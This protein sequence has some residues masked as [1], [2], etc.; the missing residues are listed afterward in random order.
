MA[1]TLTG[2][3][4]AN[5]A[6]SQCADGK[7]W[8]LCL[9]GNVPTS[10]TEWDTLY[11]NW[12]NS[13]R[14]GSAT[15][16]YVDPIAGSNSNAGTSEAP[17]ADPTAAYAVM[18][19]GDEIVIRGDGITITDEDAFAF[20]DREYSIPSGISRTNRTIIRA[21]T[22]FGIK[23]EFTANTR[24]FYY[25]A[26]RLESSQFMLI[27]GFRIDWLGDGGD[28]QYI[29]TVTSPENILTRI[30]FRRD[31]CA[32]YGGF[33]NMPA[34]YC[35]GQDI[36]GVGGAR[37]GFQM[38]GGI[39]TAGGKNILR[40]SIVRHDFTATDQPI[41]PYSHYGNNSGFGSGET[42][43]QNCFPI[44]GPYLD[45]SP[46]NNDN[47]DYTWGGFYHPKNAYDIR[48]RGCAVISQGGRAGFWV[49]D[50]SNAY[51]YQL[52][53]CAVVAENP[54]KYG[55]RNGI[56]ANSNG[57]ADRLTFVDV[58]GADLNNGITATNIYTG[59]APPSIFNP[60]NGADLRYAYGTFGAVW[61][62]TGFDAVTT[63]QLWNFPYEAEVRAAFA[64]SLPSPSGYSP[65]TN[66]ST[67]GFCANGET[68]TTYLA[69]FSSDPV[70]T[71]IGGMY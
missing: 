8:S 48:H 50:N 20:N 51:D 4:W 25:E 36:H 28:P 41:A 23:I 52:Y 18:S 35:L 59:V 32:S 17:F 13:L 22:P 64:E 39:N 16:Y 5:S 66:D 30:I 21:E 56:Y 62:E 68:F 58:D 29:G 71:V 24:N 44:D 11:T 1:I 69:G 34:N 61:G 60:T 40:R 9:P 3:I 6:Y 14:G 7:M 45:I 2:K 31:E 19:G 43:F 37:Y 70:S 10:N 65:A 67:R 38:G 49:T 46:S 33:L 63:T 55:T 57:T 54:V 47:Y 42:E 53:D 12:I 15:S 26:I 27:D